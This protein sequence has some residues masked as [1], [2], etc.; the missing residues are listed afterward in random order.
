[1]RPLEVEDVRAA[2]MYAPDFELCVM[3]KEKMKEE[4]AHNGTLELFLQKCLDKKESR[5]MFDV[6]FIVQEYFT[7]ADPRWL[8]RHEHESGGSVGRDNKRKRRNFVEV[9]GLDG[10]YVNSMTFV[11]EMLMDELWTGLTIEATPANFVGLKKCLRCG[12][13]MNHR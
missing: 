6:C 11:F 7:S 8:T 10:S 12:S 1:M 4:S 3:A 9:G 5:F 2:I 13:S